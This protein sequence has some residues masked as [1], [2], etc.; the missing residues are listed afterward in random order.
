MKL[1]VRSTLIALV[2]AAF[3]AP[4]AWAQ[5]QAPE[6]EDPDLEINVSQ[7][8]FTLQDLPTNLRLPRGK[9]AFRVTHRFS[10]PLADG[11]F[12]DLL[13]DLFGF[14]SGALIGLELRYGL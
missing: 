8:D 5:P 10:R 9:F 12:T 2:V 14:D 7:P 13:A 3:T 11:D 1:F 6:E 4:A